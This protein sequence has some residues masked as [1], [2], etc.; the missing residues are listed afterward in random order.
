MAQVTETQVLDALRTVIDSDRQAD[1]V[2]LNMISGLVV[3]DSNV[4]F[5]IE[6][7]PKRGPQLEPLRQ[8]AEKAVQGIPGVTSVTAVLTAHREAPAAPSKPAA[9]P[10]RAARRWFPACVLSSRSRRARA[11]SA[12]PPRRSTWPSGS[13]RTASE[14]GCSTR[15]STVPACRA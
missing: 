15:T 11:A 9:A 6:V 10:P 14:S 3:K 12:N 13:R 5:S 1:I 4:G 7:D 8:A 2:S